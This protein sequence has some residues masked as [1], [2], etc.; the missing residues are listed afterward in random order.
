MD[1]SRCCH[2]GASLDS[3]RVIDSAVEAV[4]HVKLMNVHVTAF[5][6]P[7]EPLVVKVS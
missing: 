5:E 3:V 1:L 6:A 7:Q 2:Y 4:I